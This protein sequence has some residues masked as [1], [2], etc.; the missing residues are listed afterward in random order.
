MTDVNRIATAIKQ[1]LCTVKSFRT[2]NDHRYQCKSTNGQDIDID[3]MNSSPQ[4]T[5][6]RV[7][8]YSD[9]YWDEGI[10]MMA[11]GN[12]DVCYI[13]FNTHGP[14]NAQLLL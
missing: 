13:T 10:G 11:G 7:T 8:T 5:K 3:I 4:I 1:S 12:A 9:E 2:I 14:V 6:I